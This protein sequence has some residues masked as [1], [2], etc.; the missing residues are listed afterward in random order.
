MYL[1]LSG[2]NWSL[3]NN[4]KGMIHETY[5]SP[6]A[7]CICIWFGLVTFLIW[8]LCIWIHPHP[9]TPLMQVLNIP[10]EI[11]SWSHLMRAP[12]LSVCMW[13]SWGRYGFLWPLKNVHA[14][15]W[16]ITYTLGAYTVSRMIMHCIYLSRLQ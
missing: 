11:R 4:S 16:H 14:F 6:D 9:I 3:L 7:T 2:W 13:F 8:K 12:I 15:V 5:F 10:R 1:W